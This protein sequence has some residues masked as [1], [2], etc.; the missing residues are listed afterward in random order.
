PPA[1][2]GYQSVPRSARRHDRPPPATLVSPA[3]GR[4]P[5]RPPA[6]WKLGS[7][8]P[9]L[10]AVRPPTPSRC[11]AVAPPPGPFPA[12]AL[13]RAGEQRPVWRGLAPVRPTRA[14]CRPLLSRLSAT[15]CARRRRRR[16]R[17]PCQRS[18]IPSPRAPPRGMTERASR[19]GQQ[20]AAMATAGR[21]AP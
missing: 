16:R 3:A 18:P 2:I 13:L 9:R 5:P 17:S 15:P 12:L 6:A 11:V 20:V 7:P 19:D 21:D 1:R 4:P 10:P 8:A 14:R